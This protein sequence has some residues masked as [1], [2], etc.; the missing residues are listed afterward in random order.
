MR[1]HFII[2][3]HIQ[4]VMDLPYLSAEQAIEHSKRAFEA[5]CDLFDSIEVWDDTG[6]IYRQERVSNQG[7]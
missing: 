6:P 2:C 1:C 3:G 7:N 5:V 4:Q